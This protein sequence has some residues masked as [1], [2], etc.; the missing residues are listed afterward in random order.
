VGSVTATV[1]RTRIFADGADVDSM[2]ALLGDPAISG[3]T[4]NPT[5]MR[6]AGHRDFEAFAR[7]LLGKVT[8]HPVSLEVCADDP[9]EIQRQ[10]M[11]ISGWGENVF[12]KVP[13]TTTGGKDLTPLAGDLAASGVKVNVTAVFTVEQ[14]R[15]AAIAVNG[16]AP[17]YVSVFAGRIA[18]A[19]VDPVPVIAEAV[20]IAEA[21]AGP[22]IIWASPREVLNLVQ[23][24][25]VGCHII[26]MTPDL[27]NKLHLI[28][29][30]L[31][32]F[33]RETVQMF[34]RDAVA[35]GLTV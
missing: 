6:A 29:K 28:G 23:A 17:S 22:E 16:G 31:L 10:A 3:F 14:A 12:V 15:A 35:S 13:V 18:D 5:L 4:T 8:D 1:R 33:S 24:D 30:D 34:H 20:R 9:K 19:G 2:V 11:I 27:I 26:T 21:C 32:E 25:S 7:D